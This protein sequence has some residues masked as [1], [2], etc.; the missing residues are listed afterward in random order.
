MKQTEVPPQNQAAQKVQAPPLMQPKSPISRNQ[1]L[2]SSNTKEKA[3]L[4]KKH[5]EKKYQD[6]KEEERKKKDA[7][8]NLF[9]KMEKLNLSP[10]E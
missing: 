3:E 4:A 6:M 9:K 1:V 7:W 8:N 5:I 2:A 10:E